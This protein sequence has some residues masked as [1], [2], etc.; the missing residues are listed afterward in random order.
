MMS[1]RQPLGAAGLL[2]AGAAVAGGH[3]ALVWVALGLLVLSLGLRLC[4]AICKRL[5]PP[6][7]DGMSAREDG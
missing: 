3:P 2:A 4:A 7:E 5:M 1:W 6:R